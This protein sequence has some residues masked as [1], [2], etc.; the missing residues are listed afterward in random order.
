MDLLEVIPKSR[1]GVDVEQEIDFDEIEF[2]VKYEKEL[3]I[4]YFLGVNGN[5][6]QVLN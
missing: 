6:N 3:D 1:G 4:G 2:T 5:G